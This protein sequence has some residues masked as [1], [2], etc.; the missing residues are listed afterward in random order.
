MISLDVK[1]GMA[2]DI[3]EVWVDDQEDAT[4]VVVVMVLSDENE[5]SLNWKDGKHDR[6]LY[7]PVSRLRRLLTDSE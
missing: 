4:S 2:S 6:T 7:M 1:Q 5:I 3:A